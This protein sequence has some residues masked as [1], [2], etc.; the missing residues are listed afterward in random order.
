MAIECL[1]PLKSGSGEMKRDLPFPLGP[2]VADRDRSP[3]W[4]LALPAL[5]T[6]LVWVVA[7]YA[8]TGRSMVDT[9]SRTETYAHGFV[10]LPIA[11]WLAWRMRDRLRAMSPSPSWL[12]VPLLA[13]AGFAWL[14]AQLGAVN[15][16]A[17][18]SF[19][20]MLVLTVP[21]VLGLRVARTM[22]FPLGF[23][24]FAVPIGDFLLPTLMDRTADFTVAALRMSG[25]PVYREGML[26]II[27]TGQ[28]SIVEACSGVRYLIASLMVGTLFAYLNYRAQW[29]RWVFVGVS[30]VV[31]IVANWIRAYMIVM[32]G[33]LSNNRL[34]TGVDHLIYG[35]VFFGVV[36]LLMFWI[37][38][39]W[40]D[41]PVT[42]PAG[43][44]IPPARKTHGVRSAAKFWIVSLAIVIVTVAWPIVESNTA[45]NAS[46][47]SVV[48]APIDVRGWTSGANAVALEPEY[49]E[50]SG[51]LRETLQR[52]DAAVTLYVAYYR[53]QD[54]RRKLVSSENVLVRSEDP[55]WHWTSSASRGVMIGDAE[56]TVNQTQL[57][58]RREQRVMA[59][60][61]YWVDGT[62]T[63]NPVMAKA[64]TAWSRLRGHGD[65][66]AA[67][68]VYTS[69]TDPQRAAETLQSFTRDAW[70]DIATAL[71][72][73]ARSK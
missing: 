27:P 49:R 48:L 71:H 51:V 13:V 16:L 32:L 44:R 40:R 4:S 59:W 62:I 14:L 31:P 19:V 41:E 50:P 57:Q 61:W 56:H 72:R 67:I 55:T 24:F 26:M 42:Q 35:W 52:G 65:D 64:L 66:S 8:A 53:S 7:W 20:A 34:A 39:R 37:G 1:V 15:A 3:G 58:G 54:V 43:I 28:W 73:A 25:V 11:V 68:I 22:M 5:A 38:T 47:D 29:R 23:L 36:M 69:E 18:A 17:Q 45:Q 12:A 46:A 30:I 33:H 9:W 2:G 6:A 63:F 60:Q 10:V 70:P 21:A